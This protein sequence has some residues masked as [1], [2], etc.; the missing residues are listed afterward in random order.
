VE[1]QSSASPSLYQKNMF[2]CLIENNVRGAANFSALRDC[3]VFCTKN[4]T[5]TTCVGALI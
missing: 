3:M 5:D 2:N 4:Y 1:W